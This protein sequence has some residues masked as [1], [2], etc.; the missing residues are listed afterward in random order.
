MTNINKEPGLPGSSFSVSDPVPSKDKATEAKIKKVLSKLN[1]AYKDEEMV[2][3]GAGF[4]DESWYPTVPIPSGFPMVDTAAGIGGY[5]NNA[6]IELY[7]PESSGK[8]YMA[9]RLVAMAQ[10]VFPDK[11][12]VY[13]DLEGGTTNE[14]MQ[15]IGID[16]AQLIKIEPCM[17]E[18]L[19]EKIYE[20]IKQGLISIVVIDSVAALQ[21]KVEMESSLE[22]Q[23]YA[24]IAKLLTRALSKLAPLCRQ[25]Q[26]AV[27]LINQLRTKM[28]AS[29][30]ANPDDTPGGRALKFFAQVRCDVRK[31][32][33]EKEKSYNIYD[34]QENV[35][36][37]YV[38]VKFIKNK[39]APPMRAGVFELY[40]DDP[41]MIM[42]VI[43]KAKKAGI[44]RIYKG[45][46]IYKTLDDDKLTYPSFEDFV[47]QATLGDLV[48]EMASRI[49][50][51][52]AA[53]ELKEELLPETFSM[54]KL[55]VI[56]EKERN[57][58][59]GIEE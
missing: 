27:V 33:D 30:F 8:S 21:P 3:V 59:L 45:E 51:M 19:F 41:D 34:T 38:V 10:R 35:I 11:Y 4:A 42:E 6:I 5:P 47:K 50:L 18:D 48:G 12:A 46:I 52:Q 54:D 55:E 28:N 7:G 24:P 57:R 15:K 25:F 44:W 43:G 53:Q 40:F 16:T 31:H 36:G 29:K 23:N 22:D 56:I 1:T 20:L 14:R 58:L 13:C 26:T 49:F 9:Q 32:Y 17:G 2:G 37:Q 39:F